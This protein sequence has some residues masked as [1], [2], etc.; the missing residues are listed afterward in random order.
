LNRPRV[1][2]AD[3]EPDFLAVST[4]L[5]EPEFEILETLADGQRVLEEAPRLKPD[6]VVLD[7]SMPLLNGIDAARQL[8]LAGCRAKIVFLTVHRDPDYVEAGFAAGAKGYVL[9][10]RLV[11]DLRSALRDVLDGRSFVSPSILPEEHDQA[12]VRT[13]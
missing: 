10:S 6:V 5:L 2:L 8:R 4:R 11:S 7:I 1:L 3:D 12:T 9:K 13:H